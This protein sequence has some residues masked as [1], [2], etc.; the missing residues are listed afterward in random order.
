MF[1]PLQSCLAPALLGLALCSPAAHAVSLF[2]SPSASATDFTLDQSDFSH[3]EL[4]NFQF[5]QNTKSVTF[6]LNMFGAP[7]TAG[8]ATSTLDL[9]AL[10]GLSFGSNGSVQLFKLDDNTP[11]SPALGL[12]TI[13]VLST[14]ATIPNLL[15]GDY[16]AVFTKGLFSLGFANTFSVN[17]ASVTPVPEAETYAML[18]LGLPLVLLVAR[19]RRQVA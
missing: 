6:T 4:I 12:P 16:K 8:D 2:D 9:S 13:N 15:D 18:A 19:R 10:L 17:P 5:L 14:Y 1:K 3:S 11:V 7:N